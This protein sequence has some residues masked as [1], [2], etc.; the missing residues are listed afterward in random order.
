VFVA[1]LS[2][3]GLLAWRLG[4]R[5]ETKGLIS[6]SSI[7]VMTSTRA[8]RMTVRVLSLVVGLFVPCVTK[9]HIGSIKDPVEQ[10]KRIAYLHISLKAVRE[11]VRLG[12]EAWKWMRNLRQERILMIASIHDPNPEA[13]KRASALYV[14]ALPETTRLVW[15]KDS[16]HLITNDR[17]RHY[18]F[19]EVYGFL[20][21]NSEVL[22][23]AAG[24]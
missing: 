20:E 8:K 24:E 18:V 21:R 7:I 9:K 2:M 13:A 6:L 5:V 14:A 1:G 4:S 17:E 15:L 23:T 19:A 12:A 10:H 16:G 3:G 11:F 22:C